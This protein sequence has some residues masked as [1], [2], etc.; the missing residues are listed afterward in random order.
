MTSVMTAKSVALPLLITIA[1]LML[2][3]SRSGGGK[4]QADTHSPIVD[5]EVREVQKRIEERRSRARAASSA[6]AGATRDSRR[7]QEQR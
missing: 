5:P 7:Q 3:C 2:G 1:L 4:T 6:K